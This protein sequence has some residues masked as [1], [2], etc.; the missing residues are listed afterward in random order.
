[1]LIATL[2]SKVIIL[3]NIYNVF[4][5]KQSHDFFKNCYKFFFEFDWDI[6][7]SFNKNTI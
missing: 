3:L 1:M 6:L 2:P 7:Y 5:Y 4:V